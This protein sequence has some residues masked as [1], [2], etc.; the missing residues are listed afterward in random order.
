MASADSQPREADERQRPPS[1]PS[2]QQ[3][4]TMGEA[5]LGAF[6]NPMR[7]PGVGPA[8]AFPDPF[9]SPSCAPGRA[10]E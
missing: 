5:P 9:A 4:R 1:R 6:R 10:A 7:W 3:A 2:G 8:R